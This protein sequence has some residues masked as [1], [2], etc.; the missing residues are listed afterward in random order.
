MTT[1]DHVLLAEVLLR[2]TAIAQEIADLRQEIATRVGLTLPG[3]RR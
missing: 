1:A 3:L 2:L